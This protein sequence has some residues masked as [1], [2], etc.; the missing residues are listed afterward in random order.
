M[1]SRNDAPRKISR[2]SLLAYAAGSKSIYSKPLASKSAPAVSLG[3]LSS[4]NTNYQ[5]FLGC[6]SQYAS[7]PIISGRTWWHSIFQ[8][9]RRSL[10]CIPAFPHSHVRK[11][12]FL[13]Q[14]LRSIKACENRTIGKYPTRI[15]GT[16]YFQSIASSFRKI[17]VND[18]RKL[19]H[20]QLR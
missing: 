1:A 7:S 4:L 16:F 2:A 19:K 6:I 17:F 18:T 10:I 12:E 8:L 20:L 5:I 3:F 13:E 15:C 11:M 9:C 14:F